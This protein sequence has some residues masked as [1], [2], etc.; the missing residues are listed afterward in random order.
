MKFIVVSFILGILMSCNQSSTTSIE[1]SSQQQS[2]RD[3]LELPAHISAPAVPEY[4]PLTAEKIALGRF[5]FYDKNLSA[6]QTQSCSSC[7]FQAL[8]FSDAVETPFGSTGHQL[9]RNSQSLSNVVYHS[10]FTWSNNGFLELED[11]LNVPIRADNPIELGVTDPHIDDVL[12]RFDSD[13]DYVKMFTAAFPD[14]ETGASINKVIFSLASFLRTMI[15]ADSAYDQYLLGDTTALTEQQKWGF[16]LFNG[17]KFECFHCHTGINFSVS[18]RDSNTTEGTIQY[19]FFN[20]GLYNVDGQGSYPAEDQGLYDLTLD[21]ADRG[22]FRPQSLRNIE[23]TAPYMHDGSIATLREVIEHYARG[24]RLIENG[25]N[26]GD[27]NLSPLKSGLI[28]PFVATDE[29]IDAV[30][31]FLESLTDYK[32]INNPKFSDPFEE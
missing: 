29:E 27:G 6:N 9:T 11:Q 21:L 26:A 13:P 4:N 23:L 3:L 8:A 32:F 12:A 15:S 1:E 16:S 17:E 18:Y 24:G 5:L 30:I 25:P 22:M 2:I 10:T 20:N 28:L 14:S 7:H 31:A 19:P